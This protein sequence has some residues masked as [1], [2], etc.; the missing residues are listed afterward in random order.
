MSTKLILGGVIA[1][2]LLTLYVYLA[3]MAISVV[4][5]ATPPDCHAS[6]TKPMAGALALIGGLV[7]ALVIAELAIT[8]PGEAPL[9]RAVSSST[10]PTES[11]IVKVATFAYLGVWTLVGLAAFV[12]GLNYPDELQSL[13]D[14]GQ[15]WLGL[16]VAAGYSYFGINR[17]E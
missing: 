14:L 6:F 11:T 15:S 3:W 4:G 2:V 8:K 10:S 5:C 16:A 9:S 17:N 1:F 12:T 7:S 13:T